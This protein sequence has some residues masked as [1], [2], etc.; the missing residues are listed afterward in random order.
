MP[1]CHV[2]MTDAVSLRHNQTH[3]KAQTAISCLSNCK[4]FEKPFNNKNKNTKEFND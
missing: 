2:F 1:C 4:K 3:F